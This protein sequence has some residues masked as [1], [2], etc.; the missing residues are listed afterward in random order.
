M[1]LPSAFLALP[2]LFATLLAAET[3]PGTPEAA[4]A[5]PSASAAK[6]SGDKPDAELEAVRRLLEA[7]GLIVVE[8]TRTES[9]APCATVRLGLSEN[10]RLRSQEFFAFAEPSRAQGLWLIRLGMPG[11]ERAG[12]NEEPLEAREELAL[13]LRG[14]PFLRDALADGG[15]DGKRD[16]ERRMHLFYAAHHATAS[17]PRA[18]AAF[19]A[20]VSEALSELFSVE[21]EGLPLLVT[22]SERK[23][24]PL[25][26]AQKNLADRLRVRAIQGLPIPRP[27][28]PQAE[29]PLS[30]ASHA[31]DPHHLHPL[32][33][34]DCAP[35]ILP[36]LAA[37]GL[38]G[39]AG[40]RALRHFLELGA[41][42]EDPAPLAALR[43][44]AHAP[45]GEPLDAW[46]LYHLGRHIMG[47]L[48]E[49][50][51]VPE[52][53]KALDV[54]RQ[55]ARLGCEAALG[56]YLHVLDNCGEPLVGA[57]SH[58]EQRGRWEALWRHFNPH[59][60]QEAV[61]VEQAY[62]SGDLSPVLVGVDAEGEELRQV[63]LAV[64]EMNA[65]RKARGWKP[66]EV[67]EERPASEPLAEDAPK[68]EDPAGAGSSRGA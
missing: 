43:A 59:E 63:R 42:P 54:L 47:A 55:S 17:D 44:L 11:E 62:R 60:I 45:G 32:E 36:E 15:D 13:A 61:E 19:M 33:S 50:D 23:R 51:R 40:H 41:R 53:I 12:L 38:A 2:L 34:A 9:G 18:F 52:V 1:H 56:Y 57:E 46:A 5:P 7:G 49:E 25:V 65:V 64:D 8:V 24:Q 26:M 6:P 28:S 21:A 35:E 39:L 31:L 20:D 67:V 10:P 30:M 66:I 58:W 4:V 14:A 29:D 48:P 68:R 3:P 27:G 37:S 22:M 16:G